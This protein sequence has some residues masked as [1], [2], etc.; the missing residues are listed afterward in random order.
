M[1]DT[2]TA[3]LGASP[4]LGA[5]GPTGDPTASTPIVHLLVLRR[6]VAAVI[7]LTGAGLAAGSGS[8]G[9]ARRQTGRIVR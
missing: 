8:T 5:A 7:A 9:S 1:N 2:T 6:A 3:S 4:V